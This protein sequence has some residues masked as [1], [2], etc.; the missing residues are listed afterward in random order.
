VI[1][2]DERTAGS[3]NAANGFQEAGKEVLRAMMKP[4][5]ECDEV[6]AFIGNLRG[7]DRL[8]VV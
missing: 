5:I 4:N 6:N 1:A 8:V 2:Q 3:Q 7:G